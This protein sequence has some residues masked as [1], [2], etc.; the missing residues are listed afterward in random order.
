MAKSIK[1]GYMLDFRNPPGAGLEFAEL[2]AEM[3]RQ[4]EFVEGAGFDSV[5]LTEHHFTD[6]GYMP[7]IMPA[8][9][10]VAART[11]RVSIGTYVLLAPFYHPLRLAEDAAVIDVIS[12]GRLRMGIGTA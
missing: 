4:I 5:W 8:L 11:R 12:K 1:F 3:F 10:A 2:Y 9:A 6:D 7:A